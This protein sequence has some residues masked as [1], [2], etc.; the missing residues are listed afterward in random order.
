MDPLERIKKRISYRFHPFFL[1]GWKE[2]PPHLAELL[3]YLEPIHVISIIKRGVV[4]DGYTIEWEENQ[5]E[6]YTKI[7]TAIEDLLGREKY[8]DTIAGNCLLHH[9]ESG[10][11]TISFFWGP[12]WHLIPCTLKPATVKYLLTLRGPPKEKTY[13]LQ[14]ALWRFSIKTEF[15]AGIPYPQIREEEEP[16]FQNNTIKLRKQKVIEA[17]VFSGGAPR[18]KVNL[19]PNFFVEPKPQNAKTF[20]DLCFLT[21]SRKKWTLS[22]AIPVEISRNPQEVYFCQPSQSSPNNPKR[23]NFYVAET[24]KRCP[25]V[26]SLIQYGYIQL[27]MENYTESWRD[28]LRFL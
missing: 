23:L 21:Q 17:I 22:Q 1:K 5:E 2:Y 24:L 7:F 19:S 11:F 18:A 3:S 10:L 26:S 8:R 6:K 13:Y 12:T 27:L 15:I 14:A 28:L 16:I 9:H 25:G 4:V 20:G